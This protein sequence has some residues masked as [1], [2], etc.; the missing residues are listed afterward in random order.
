MNKNEFPYGLLGI[1][2]IQ[3][4]IYNVLKGSSK[5]RKGKKPRV[6]F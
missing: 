2:I 5:A 6:K 4:S 3:Q 1:Q